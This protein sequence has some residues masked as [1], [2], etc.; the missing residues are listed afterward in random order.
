VSNGIK[1]VASAEF[2][3]EGVVAPTVDLLFLSHFD[4]DH[5]SGVAELL[6]KVRVRDVVIPLVPLW[7]RLAMLFESDEYVSKEVTAFFLD[8]V[9]SL[10][11]LADGRIERIIL[12]E[13]SSPGDEGGL[14]ADAGGVPEISPSQREQSFYENNRVLASPTTDGPGDE[15]S[16]LKDSSSSRVVRLARGGSIL[17]KYWEFVP[18]NDA[19]S[20]RKTDRTFIAET[21]RLRRRLLAADA[22]DNRPNDA[23]R[24]LKEHYERR[25]KRAEARNAISLFLYTGPTGAPASSGMSC[26]RVLDDIFCDW[27]RSVLLCGDGYLNRPAKWSDLRNYLTPARVTQVHT[28]QVMHHGSRSNWYAGLA[29]EISPRVAV[30]CADPT[31]GHRHPDQCVVGDFE[32]DFCWVVNINRSEHNFVFWATDDR[33]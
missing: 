33:I 27:K 32:A 24:H 3:D 2:Q 10:W 21:E 23:L 6:S 15:Y 29:A 7:Q 26:C 20:K 5:I 22:R 30:F 19:W 12:V 16:S 17:F 8:P 28:L 25:F 9:R 4:R 11:A 31:F 13:P 18:Y 1:R 14:D